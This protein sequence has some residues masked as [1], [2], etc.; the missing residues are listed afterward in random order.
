MSGDITLEVSDGTT[1]KS[2]STTLRRDIVNALKLK[3]STDPI[4]YFSFPAADN[5]DTIHIPNSMDKLSLYLGESKGNIAK[6]AIDTDILVDSNL[7]GDPA[8][9]I[10]NKGTDSSAKGS[11]FTIKNTDATAKERTMRI[12]LY[13]LNN[14]V[15]ATKDIKVIYDF[16]AGINT[17]SLSGSTSDVVPTDVSEID[18]VNL[19]K[20]KDL[21]KG[22]KEQ[23]RLKL[24]QYFSAL[25]ENW[26]DT[27]EKT[28][29]IIDFENYVDVNS[30]LDAPTKDLFYSLLE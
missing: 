2:T 22:A 30:A 7:N 6:Y 19:E 27:R 28:K 17:E 29:T 23:D 1:S 9:D 20:L 14:V 11:I 3:K 8:D 12:T 18:K 13:D 26:F 15:I 25:K 21:I 4:V 24:M 10:D 16:N 5:N